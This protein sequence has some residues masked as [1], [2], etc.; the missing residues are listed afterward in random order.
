MLDEAKKEAWRSCWSEVDHVRSTLYM[1]LKNK[2][3]K[4]IA[5]NEVIDLAFGKRSEFYLT[6]SSQMDLDRQQ[7]AKFFGTLCLQMSYHESVK[8]LFKS[9]SL[10]KDKCLIDCKDYMEIWKKMAT[11]KRV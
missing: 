4:E 5:L 8:C 11:S 6:F 1:L 2:G 10:I 3:K 9:N 7:F